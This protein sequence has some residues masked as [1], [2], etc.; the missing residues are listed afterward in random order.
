MSFFSKTEIADFSTAAGFQ[1]GIQA[2]LS[3]MA[4]CGFVQTSDTGQLDPTTISSIVTSSQSTLGYFVFRLNDALQSSFPVYIKM[5]IGGSTAKYFNFAWQFGAGTNGAGTITNS[6][7]T[8]SMYSNA[9]F[10]NA[11]GSTSLP[12]FGATGEGYAWFAYQCGAG[13]YGA[14]TTP[15]FLSVTRSVDVSGNPTADGV[16]IRYAY[17]GSTA[18]TTVQ[19]YKNGSGVYVVSSGY[20]A[21]WPLGKTTM[22]GDNNAWQPV[23]DYFYLPLATRNPYCVWGLS[24]DLPGLSQFDWAPVSGSATRH[25]IA[26]NMAGVANYWCYNLSSSTGV[27]CLIAE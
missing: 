9:P 21:F 8:Q 2:M 23:V 4:Q 11:G 15:A 14:Q 20:G 17:P 1:A 3:Q 6:W 10:T 12:S 24:G 25:Y 26:L 19:A 27:I 13:S 16:S 5:T 18:T 22:I 7:Y